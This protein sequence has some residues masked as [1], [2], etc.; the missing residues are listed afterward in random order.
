MD[1]CG[2]ALSSWYCSKARACCGFADELLLARTR[3][4]LIPAR[5]AE[6]DERLNLHPLLKRGADG[7]TLRKLLRSVR[8][9]KTKLQVLES[10]RTGSAP[11]RCAH[12]A[13]R[14]S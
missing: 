5:S 12:Q 8:E 10:R 9:A 4:M 3:W 11:Q 7:A 1:A 14:S 2:G 6:L 13:G